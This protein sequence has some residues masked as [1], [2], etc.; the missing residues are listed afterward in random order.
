M[1]FFIER[2]NIRQRA[3]GFT[4]ANRLGS[5]SR[6]PL[7]RT[8]KYTDYS[9]PIRLASYVEAQLIIAEIQGGQN[10]VNI[11]NTLHTA[12]G[13]PAFAGT[14]ATAIKNQVIDERRR[15]FFLEGLRMGDL[16][17]YGIA[18]QWNRGG[19]Q[20]PY[21]FLQFGGTECFPFPDVEK[22]GNPNFQGK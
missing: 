11:I 21:N 6:T 17:Q 15:E 18:K 19:T 2:P 13:L 5:D 7:W 14:D 16:R 3:A 22:Q 8:A 1:I 9:T 20:N 4:N 12:A 10:A